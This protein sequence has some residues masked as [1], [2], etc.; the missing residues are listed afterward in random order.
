MVI[1]IFI[2]RSREVGEDG[3]LQ[4]L[5][6]KRIEVFNGVKQFL[7]CRDD[8]VLKKLGFG[9]FDLRKNLVEGEGV[10]F[11]GDD[12]GRHVIRCI[13]KYRLG[14]LIEEVLDHALVFVDKLIHAH[15]VLLLFS[16]GS[17]IGD[18]L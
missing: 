3:H 17:F 2:K 5:K 1:D 9:A 6:R 14:K 8:R 18:R 7:V 15:H 11:R 10:V 13:R 16:K 12:D 4:G